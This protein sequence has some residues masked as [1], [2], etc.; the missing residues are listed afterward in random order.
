[1]KSYATATV[2]DFLR[3]NWN[4]TGSPS[5]GR[6]NKLEAGIT[7]TVNIELKCITKVV[8]SVFIYFL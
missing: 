6:E 2:V 5:F 1:M 4:E 7:A 8:T 3:A